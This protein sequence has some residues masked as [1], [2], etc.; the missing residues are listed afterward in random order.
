MTKPEQDF[1]C[2]INETTMEGS[3]VLKYRKRVYPVQLP[4]NQ[5]TS[6]KKTH[7]GYTW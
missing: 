4:S 3:T 1:K 6:S 2:G 5:E 7:K